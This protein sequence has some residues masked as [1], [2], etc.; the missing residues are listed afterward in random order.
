MAMYPIGS[1]MQAFTLSLLVVVSACCKC[2]AHLVVENSLY[3]I[4]P[5]SS[6][7]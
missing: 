5:R 6:L 2:R 7:I 1:T 3:K 4:K